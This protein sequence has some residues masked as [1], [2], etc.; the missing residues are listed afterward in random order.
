MAYKAS[1]E[2][3]ARTLLACRATDIAAAF[4][5]SVTARDGVVKAF[6]RAD[7]AG[8]LA[9]AAAIDARRKAG[10]PLGK[11]AGVPVAV[12][13]EVVAQ[14]GAS[15]DDP[16][17]QDRFKGLDVEAAEESG[18]GGQRGRGAASEADGVSAAGL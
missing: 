12:G 5:A 16:L 2:P 9:Q 3:L 8:I 18:E 4:L 1:T 7:E 6:L 17:A 13:G 11:L 14:I 10:R 15:P